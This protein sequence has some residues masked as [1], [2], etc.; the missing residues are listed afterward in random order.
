[1][2]VAVV[3]TDIVTFTFSAGTAA[4]LIMTV[5]VES[6]DLFT[7]DNLKVALASDIENTILMQVTYQ[8]PAASI[9]GVADITVDLWP[10]IAI[11]AYKDG[12]SI[13]INSGSE[14]GLA[15][16]NPRQPAMIPGSPPTLDPITSYPCT[17]HI[18]TTQTSLWAK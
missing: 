6:S 1:M 17:F 5:S 14:V 16:L 9:P 18:T 13:A 15:T 8:T 2:Y 3:E 4:P 11:Y 7:V 12:E 10:E